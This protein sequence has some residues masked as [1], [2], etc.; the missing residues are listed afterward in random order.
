VDDQPLFA[1]ARAWRERASRLLEASDLPVLLGDHG[2]IVFSG[3]YAYDTMMSP[4]IDLHLLLDVF[5]RQSAV[6]VLDALIRQDWWNTYAFGDW[7]QERFRATVGGRAPRGYLLKLGATFED[8]YWNVDAWVL[9]HGAYAGDLWAPKMAAITGEQRLALLRL[10]RARAIGE[11]QSPGV[12]IYEAVVDHDVT[13]PE[14][15]LAWQ[16]ANRSAE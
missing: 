16:A 5:S 2:R 8:R 1:D 11:L 9:D 10:K 6:E 12:D 7:V 3:S 4:D 14:A 15:F 13:M